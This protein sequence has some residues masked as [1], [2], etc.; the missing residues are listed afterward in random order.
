[1]EEFADAPKEG[2]DEDLSI[3]D[4]AEAG[5]IAEDT[6]NEVDPFEDDVKAATLQAA[7]ASGAASTVVASSVKAALAPGLGVAPAPGL[8]AAPGLEV[9]PV[10]DLNMNFPR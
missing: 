10:R 9:A 2:S 4:N 6:P 5:L 8:G 1:M 7:S 3:E